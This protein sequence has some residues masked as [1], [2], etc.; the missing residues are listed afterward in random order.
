[1]ANERKATPSTRT[2]AV[3]I[4]ATDP[5]EHQA[6]VSSGS[7][8]STAVRASTLTDG[9][10]PDG[11]A[12]TPLPG[13]VHTMR[14]PAP[15]TLEAEIG[16]TG[17]AHYVRMYWDGQNEAHH[18]D[19]RVTGA[20]PWH[21][22]TRFLQQPTIMPELAGFN[23]AGG[24]GVLPRHQ[25]VLDRTTRRL[26][27]MPSDQAQSLVAEQWTRQRKRFTWPGH[28]TAPPDPHAVDHSATHTRA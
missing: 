1:M 7:R 5:R 14:T 24:R 11:A 21:I 25:L 3:A 19:G 16:Y 12:L 18:D 2:D 22:Y 23:I 26:F 13:S 28:R 20:I 4:S 6:D 9:T 8:P 10:P 17:A 27:V 15:A